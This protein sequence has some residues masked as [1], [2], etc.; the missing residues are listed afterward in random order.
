MAIS[1]LP[2]R[3]QKKEFSLSRELI[4]N[5]SALLAL[6]VLALTGLAYLGSSFY[7]ISLNNDIERVT[8]EAKEIQQKRNIVLEE[9]VIK[10]DSK[11]SSISALLDSHTFSSKTLNFLEGI[12]HHEVY[13]TNFSFQASDGVIS[14]S[15]LTENYVTFGEQHIALEQ[16]KAI[17]EVTVSDVKFSKTGKISFGLSFKIDE[18]VYKNKP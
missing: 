5:K 15:G 8:L 14:V 1:L 12:T 9:E 18:A 16:E 17:S 10:F 3:K 2:P 7:I 11:L 4:E 13:F 6:G